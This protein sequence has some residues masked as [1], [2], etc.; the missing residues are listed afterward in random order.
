MKE[1]LIHLRVILIAYGQVSIVA[2]PGEGALDF[3]AFA[4][5]TQRATVVEE[6]FGAPAAMRI[7]SHTSCS[8]HCRNRRQQVLAAGYC[9]GKSRQ[10]APLLSIQ[11]MP[12]SV[13]RLSAQGRPR[14]RSLDNSGSIRFHCFSLRNDDRISSFSS[15][16]PHKVQTNLF[17]SFPC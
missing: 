16:P 11:T 6:G 15:S 8:S 14:L 13:A 1:G 7:L 3:P 5:A 10:C 9:V 17:P 2:P 12:S 4:V